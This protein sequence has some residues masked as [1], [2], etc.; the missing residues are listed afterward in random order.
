MNPWNAEA[1]ATPA[2][3]DP[4]AMAAALRSARWIWRAFPYFAW[5]FPERGPAFGRSDAGYLT[6]LPALPAPVRREQVRWLARLL[7][8]RGMPSLLLEVQLEVLGRAGRRVGWADADVMSGLAAELRGARRAVMSDAAMGACDAHFRAIWGAAPR[9]RG[10][11]ALIAAEVADLKLG[12]LDRV[13]A[14]RPTLDWLVARGLDDP[15]WRH[16]CRDTHRLAAEGGG[17]P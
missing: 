4:L 11:G 9:G 13:S 3:V 8:T 1:G 15:R 16:A 10:T 5:R 17:A 7:A 12:H 6:T 2:P 14:E